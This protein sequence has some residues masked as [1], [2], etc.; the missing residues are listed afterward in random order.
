MTKHHVTLMLDSGVFSAWSRDEQIN[1]KDYIR[2]VKRLDPYLFSY[3]NCDVIPGKFGTKRT[4][5]DIRKSGAGSYRNQ[6]ILKDA[7][8]HPIPV[9][10]Q[11]ESFEWLDKLLTDGEPYIG[12]S[13]SKDF[14]AEDQRKWLDQVFSIL[15]DRK[16]RPLVKTHGFGITNPRLLMR[17]P[18]YSVDSTTWTLT[19]GY[20]QV[21]I[22][23]HGDP[24]YYG[25]TPT[26]IVISGVQHNN[27]TNQRLQYEAMAAHV[28]SEVFRDLRKNIVDQYL[29]AE[30]EVDHVETRYGTT[31]RRRA[32]LIYYLGLADTIKDVRFTEPPGFLN[33]D[34]KYLREKT[35]ARLKPIQIQQVRIMF[36]SNLSKEWSQLLND[37]GANTRLLSYYELKDKPDQVL[38]DYVTKGM[39]EEYKK[40]KPKSSW[41]SE[42]YRNYRRL[43]Q[44]ARR[45]EYDKRPKEG[46]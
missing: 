27:P 9:F 29:N 24:K 46:E 43:E 6:Q 15:C 34:L 41:H 32:M 2:Y 20:G 21:V 11:E 4:S 13:S 45:Q 44:L 16:G 30:C 36:A 38:I 18:F 28:P 35:Q 31:I 23:S 10:H 5:A 37:V 25:K 12:I 40:R 14:W 33:L 39:I 8:L 17:Y 3:V 22:P 26:R 7:G 42:S 1:I 19:P